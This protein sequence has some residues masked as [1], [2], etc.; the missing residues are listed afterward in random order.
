MREKKKNIDDS[1]LLSFFA[2]TARGTED[3]LRQEIEKMGAGETTADVGIVFFRST[4]ADS[5]RINYC[6]RLANKIVLILDERPVSSYEDLYNQASL[7]EWDRYF[8]LHQ[9]FAVHSGVIFSRIDHSAYASLKVKDAIA[10]FFRKKFS[11]RPSVNKGIPDIPV[12]LRVFKNRSCLGLNLS[13]EPLFKRGYRTGTG[14]APLKETLAA[15]LVELASLGGHKRIIDPMAG[16]GTLII[17]AAIKHLNIP[18]GGW[19]KTFAFQNLKN[20]RAEPFQKIKKEADAAMRRFSDI[21][22]TAADHAVSFLPLLRQ[23]IRQAGLEKVI[24][25][26]KQDFFNPG[27]DM[28]NS[29]ILL[30]PPY[31]S[32]LKGDQDLNAFYKKMGDTLKHH[33]KGSTAYIFTEHADTIKHIGLRTSRRVIL[34]N[35]DIECRLLEYRMF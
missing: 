23:N 34:Y 32:R 3:L 8:T 7:V 15:G 1:R 18:P 13:G 26:Q 12:E 19:R 10:D 25:V 22:F 16:S 14:P 35:G 24:Q 20:Y 27:T 30:N 11:A 4:L 2:T 9:T 6:S 5:Y 17:E 29:L 31:G 28:T 21:R 33:A